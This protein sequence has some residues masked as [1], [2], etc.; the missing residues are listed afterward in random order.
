[1]G[2]TPRTGTAPTVGL[3]PTTPFTEAGHTMDPSVSVPTASGTSPAATAAPDPEDD[4]PALRSRAHG[5]ATSPPVADQPLVDRSERM[6]AHS[7][8]LVE[9][10]TTAPASRSRPTSG[11]SRAGRPRSDA[12][13]AAP[14]SPV[15]SMLSFTITGTPCNGPRDAPRSRSM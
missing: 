3:S 7:D 8:R 10:S 5:L 15:T 9:A 6:L 13:P 14:G 11:A 12:E 4:P 2:T 1:M